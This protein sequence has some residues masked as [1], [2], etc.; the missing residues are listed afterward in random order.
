[1]QELSLNI[2]DIAENSVRA[3]AL[4]VR[5]DVRVIEAEKL[6]KIVISDDGK[7]MDE[8]TAKGAMD[9]FYTTRTTRKVGL[10]LPYL[11]MNAELTGGTMDIES[12][13]GTGTKVTSSFGIEHIDRAPLGDMGQTMSILAGANPEMDFVYSLDAP[14][15]SFVFDTREIKAALEEVPISEPEVMSYISSFITE[16]TK[17][18]IT[19]YGI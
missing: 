16:N 9:P 17:E 18:L 15:G 1:M 7:G 19:K 13:P 14:E 10:G 2:L 11:K 4:L 12:A 5:V 6:L 8:R 3:K